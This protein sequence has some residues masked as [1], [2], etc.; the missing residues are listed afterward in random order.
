MSVSLE[1]L[2]GVE[3]VKIGLNEGRASIAFHPNN[4]VKLEQVTQVVKDK[5][6]TPQEARVVA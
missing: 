3:S 4:T 1:K 6:F 5:G 2:P